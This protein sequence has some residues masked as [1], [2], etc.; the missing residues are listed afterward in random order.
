MMRKSVVLLFSFIFVGFVSAQEKNYINYH[1]KLNQSKKL[2]AEG[3][4]E[5]AFE[6]YRTT[7]KE[8]SN[9]FYKDIHNACICAI[10]CEK[11]AEADKL[12]IDLVLHGYTLNDMEQSSFDA[13]RKSKYW[14]PFV[15][16]YQKL[17]DKYE[18][19]LD[20]EL[21]EKYYRLFL[22]DQRVAS[23]GK[24]YGNITNDSAF[25]EIFQRL[26]EAYK[27]DGI[28]D[29][30]RNKDTMNIKYFILYRHYFGLKNNADN[31]F[32]L[33]SKS[34]IYKITDDLKLKEVLLSEI[35]NGNISPQFYADAVSYNNYSRPFG[36][37]ALKIDFKTEQVLLYMNLKEQEREEKNK[38]RKAIGLMPLS[39]GNSAV[40]HSTWY[41]H[42]PF[43]QIKDSLKSYQNCKNPLVKLKVIRKLEAE[44]KNKYS[45]SLT[46]DFYIDDY[47]R[48]KETHFFG[49]EL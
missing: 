23:S 16:N 39:E 8:Y 18:L 3:K 4:F 22:E 11:F 12:A 32:E 10:R 33:K 48:I 38:N 42:Y 14:A 25:V 43:K 7:F 27:L 21:R 34:D 29:Y 41:T 46:T 13:Y 6:N 31:N 2:I 47:N 44:A 24:E 49:L 30:L 1:Q 5:L 9:H 28:P 40:L 35:K 20:K 17:R 26:Y 19:R 36:K 45:N 37:P 15:K